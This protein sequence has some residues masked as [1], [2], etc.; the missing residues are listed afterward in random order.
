MVRYVTLKEVSKHFKEE[1][2]TRPL[3][4]YF[5]YPFSVLLS[6]IAISLGIHAH[7]V[8]LLGLVLSLTSAA[9]IYYLGGVWMILAAILFLA[10]LVVDLS[11]GTVARF[12]NKKNAM[13][14]WLDESTG[15]ISFCVVFFALMMK[16]FVAN[17]DLL[18]IVLGTYNIFSYMMINYAALLSDNLR[19]KFNLDN[20]LD[21][22]REKA[23]KTLFGISPGMFAFSLDIQWT[24]VALGILFNAPYTLFIIFG[25]ISSAQWMVRYIIFFGK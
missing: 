18:I 19:K 2:L 11:D 1:H 17:G 16:T 25:I 6:W 24:L 12:N 22:V 23:S 8:N 14:K 3:I 21:K 15:F 7:F 9:I 10:G 4:R 13:G 5:F 20:P